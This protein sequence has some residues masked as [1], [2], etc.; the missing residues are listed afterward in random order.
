MSL[1]VSPSLHIARRDFW[2]MKSANLKV[3]FVLSDC[4]FDTCED[5]R[6][7]LVVAFEKAQGVTDYAK[8][9]F[10]AF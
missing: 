10:Q 2:C 5:V 3:L 4:P 7:P 1:G 6:F 8:H 9:S